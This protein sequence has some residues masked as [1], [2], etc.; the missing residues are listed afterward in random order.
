M[1]SSIITSASIFAGTDQI[2]VVVFE[3]SIS[4]TAAAVHL[5]ADNCGLSY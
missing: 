2:E 4:F 1:P 3:Q 5:V